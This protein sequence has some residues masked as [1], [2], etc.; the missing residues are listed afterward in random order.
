MK[1]QRLTFQCGKCKRNFTFQ[2]KITI[3]QEWIFQCPYCGTELLLKLEPFRKKPTNLIRG[4]SN[5]EES[6]EWEYDFPAVILTQPR[7]L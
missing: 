2:K 4:A 6:L 1:K 7:T 5:T 3:E